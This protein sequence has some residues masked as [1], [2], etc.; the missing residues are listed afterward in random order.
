MD[1]ADLIVFLI[2]LVI[3]LAGGVVAITEILKER[4]GEKE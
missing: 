1:I 4:G 3:V 2:A